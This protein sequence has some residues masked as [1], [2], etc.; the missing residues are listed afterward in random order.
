MTLRF[1]LSYI[2]VNI[3]RILTN[4]FKTLIPFFRK[5]SVIA[6]ATLVAVKAPLSTGSSASKQSMSEQ[7]YN[8]CATYQVL[9]DRVIRA[10][11]TQLGDAEHLEDQRNQALQFLQTAELAS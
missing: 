6:T 10:L 4:L 5:T 2:L 7:L 8:L 3:F 11:C 9:H 1:L